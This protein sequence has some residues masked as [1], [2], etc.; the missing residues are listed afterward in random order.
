[1]K[2]RQKVDG[3]RWDRAKTG[4]WRKDEKC[5]LKVTWAKSRR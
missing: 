4:G 1:M 2:C 5:D 3:E